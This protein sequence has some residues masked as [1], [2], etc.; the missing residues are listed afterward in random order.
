MWL[1]YEEPD[2][3]EFHVSLCVPPLKKLKTIAEQLKNM[4]SYVMISCNQEGNMDLKVE[5]PLVTVVTHFHNLEVPNYEDLSLAPTKSW[6]RD[7]YASVR[8]DIKRLIQFLS[9]QQICPYKVMCNIIHETAVH[10][11][12]IHDDVKLNFFLPSMNI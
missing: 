9:S 8:I 10:F 12:L 1:D 11:F 2:I 5:S 7:R 4:S 3:P 6:S